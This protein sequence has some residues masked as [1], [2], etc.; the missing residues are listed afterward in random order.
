MVGRHSHIGPVDGVRSSS[1]AE[2]GDVGSV[3]EPQMKWTEPRGPDIPNAY[4]L[5]VRGWK[6]L[7]RLLGSSRNE[8]TNTVI[9]LIYKSGAFPH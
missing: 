3:W 9:H 5:H 1:R 8:K 7:D 2:A 4:Q 6:S